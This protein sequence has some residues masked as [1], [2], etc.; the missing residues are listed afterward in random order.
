MYQKG[1]KVLT[2]NRWSLDTE[3]PFAVK[4]EILHKVTPRKIQAGVDVEARPLIVF[5]S[6]EAALDCSNTYNNQKMKTDLFRSFVV[7]C[8]FLP[9]EQDLF[10][11]E[12]KASEVICLK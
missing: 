1:Y 7:P 11:G 3:T 5:K 6:E 2:W 8:L 12:C 10:G 9:I 4:Y